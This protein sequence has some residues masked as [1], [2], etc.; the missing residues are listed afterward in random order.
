MELSPTHIVKPLFQVSRPLFPKLSYLQLTHRAEVGGSEHCLAVGGLTLG[1]DLLSEMTPE[2][3][4]LRHTLPVESV[5]L[6]IV[7]TE[8]GVYTINEELLIVWSYLQL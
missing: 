7:V 2:T 8:S 6:S 1:P 3:L 5:I 4:H